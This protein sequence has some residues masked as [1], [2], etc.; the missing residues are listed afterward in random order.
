MRPTCHTNMQIDPEKRLHCENVIIA[1][2]SIKYK[3][4]SRDVYNKHIIKVNWLDIS[5]VITILSASSSSSPVIGETLTHCL[6][7]L[8]QCSAT[9][10]R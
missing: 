8:N 3:L 5:Y 1:I 10:E 6:E 2:V 4:L 7:E 9:D